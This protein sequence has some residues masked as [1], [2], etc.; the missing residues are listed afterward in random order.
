MKDNLECNRWGAYLSKRQPLMI[1]RLQR[2]IMESV[3]SYGRGKVICYLAAHR[4]RIS[5]LQVY[6]HWKVAENRDTADLRAKGK[7]AHSIKG[8]P[9]L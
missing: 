9:S 1:D 7:R 4:H 2:P 6:Y 5:E 8:V 3:Q